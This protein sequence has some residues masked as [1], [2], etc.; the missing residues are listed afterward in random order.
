MP[1]VIK[2]KFGREM[3]FES[4]F[5]KKERNGKS[6]VDSLDIRQKGGMQRDSAG[7]GFFPFFLFCGLNGNKAGIVERK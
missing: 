2:P 7:F 3:L 1:E 6:G 4:A 5:K